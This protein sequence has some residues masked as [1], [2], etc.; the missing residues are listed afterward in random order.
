MWTDTGKIDYKAPE[1]FTEGLYDK[2]IDVWSI[3]IILFT[4][5]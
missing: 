4:L 1:I 5:V 3:G 2:K